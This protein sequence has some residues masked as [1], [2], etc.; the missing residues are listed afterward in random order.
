[1]NWIAGEWA[2]K[3]VLASSDPSNGETL[4]RFVETRTHARRGRCHRGCPPYVRSHNVGTGCPSTSGC[5]ALR[6]AQA[7]ELSAEPLAE[8]LTRENGK[9]MWAGARRNAR[10][11]F[12]S[13]LLRGTRAP[14]CR[15]RH[16]RPE[17][18]HH[19]HDVAREAAGVAG[20]HRAVERSRRAARA[21]PLPPALAAGCT[22]IVKPAA[23]TSS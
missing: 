19:L 22:A 8:L 17:R 1:M 18:G 12:R 2:G 9:T 13:A 23:Q 15:S 3:P 5:S 10:R 20:D 7:L 16:R 6:W 4:G 14:H 21:G 11:D